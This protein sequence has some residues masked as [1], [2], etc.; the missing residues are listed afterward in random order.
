MKIIVLQLPIKTLPKSTHK[1]KP[2]YRIDND[3][4][5][6]QLSGSEPEIPVLER[7]L[8]TC[9]SVVNGKAN[10]TNTHSSDNDDIADQL[11]GSEPEIPVL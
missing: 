2:T 5:A 4:I 10:Q 11:S 6:D 8:H 9:V 1:H 3:D 7:Y